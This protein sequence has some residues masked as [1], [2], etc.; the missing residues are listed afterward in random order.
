L[1]DEKGIAIQAFS[2][3]SSP[4][5]AEPKDENKGMSQG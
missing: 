2:P 1:A 3:P 5:G 4:P